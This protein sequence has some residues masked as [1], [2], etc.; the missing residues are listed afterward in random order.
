[1]N[2]LRRILLVIYSLLLIA[3]A[4]G[5]GVLAWNQDDQLDF[6]IE[7]L[8][9]QGIITADDAEKYILTAILGAVG[10]LAVLTALIAVWPSR[11]RSR[12]ALRIRQADGGTVEVTAESIESLLREELEALPEVQGAKPR[13]S[14][15]SGAVDTYLDVQIE[16]ST[17]IA[18]ATRVL[19]STV[20]TVLREQVGVTA[21]R[22][23]TIRITYTEMAARPIGM[24]RE[25]TATAP[26]ELRP[27]HQGAYS[28]ETTPPSRPPEAPRYT[29]SEEDAPAP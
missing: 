12:G 5:I 9:V 23:P 13:V 7:D 19:G 10:A 14:L 24:R 26:S 11:A 6:T 28:S 3:A 1:V 15:A 4:A 27:Q 16:S 29:S 2:T 17:S 20:E 8:N 21:V 22:R 25:R 18:D